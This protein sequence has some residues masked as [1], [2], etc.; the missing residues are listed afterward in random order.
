MPESGGAEPDLSAAPGLGL[1]PGLRA[2]PTGIPDRAGPTEADGRWS[3]GRTPLSPPRPPVPLEPMTVSDV[4]DGAW[5]VFK[6]RPRTVFLL[7]AMIVVPFQVLQAVLA[8]GAVGHLDA[9]A[10]FGTSASGGSG[11]GIDT[12]LLGGAYLAD[13]V[14]GLSLFILGGAIAHLVTSWY[15]GRDV[16]PADAAKAALRKLHIYLGAFLLLLVPKAFSC[17]IG[18]PFVIPLFMFTAPAIMI[19]NLGPIAGAR[20]SF[21]LAIRRYWSCVWIWLLAFIIELVVNSMIERIPTTLADLVPTIDQWQDVLVPAF[22]GFAAL[23][24]APFIVSVCVLQYLDLR[25]R[26]EGLDLDREAARVFADA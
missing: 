9:D 17:G 5:A 24:T 12:A 15:S 14:H 23:L 18:L 20:R 26:S 22:N 3:D 13:V 8:R 11:S 21:Q 10:L 6:A 1:G 16:T 19:E 25:V 7:S 2:G 4:L